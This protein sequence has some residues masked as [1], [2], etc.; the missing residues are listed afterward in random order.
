MRTTIT[1][2]GRVTVPKSIRDRLFLK[3]GYRVDFA[4]GDNG[5]LHVRP[6]KASVTE[7]KGILPKPATPLTLEQMDE[8]IARASR[9]KP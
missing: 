6:A 1:T 4:L 7:L 8:A 5:E 3:P 9:R 2:G